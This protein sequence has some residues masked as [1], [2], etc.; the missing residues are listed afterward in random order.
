M[1]GRDELV[2]GTLKPQS[3]KLTE[4]L[5]LRSGDPLLGAFP[6]WTISSPRLLALISGGIRSAIFEAR[7]I[8]LLDLDTGTLTP[9]A[10]TIDTPWLC[11]R[12]YCLR[13]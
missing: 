8:S 6:A 4:R 1:K 12:E 5:V 10:F 7:P 9:D 2:I 11:H 13:D 3:G